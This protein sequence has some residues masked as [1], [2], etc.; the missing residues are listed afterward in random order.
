[1]IVVIA[2]TAVIALI[3][4]LQSAEPLARDVRHAP[5]WDAA[6]PTTPMSYIGVYPDGVPDSY[7]GVTAFTAATGIK[8]RLVPY[9][10]GWLEPFQ[11]GFARVVAKHGAVP[12]V[13]IDPTRT[14]LAAIAAGRYDSY[15]ITYA[16]AVRSY[17]HPVILSFGHEMNGGWYS[18]GHR[19]TSPAAFVAAWRHIV[20][21]FRA[22]GARNITWLWTINIE[23]SPN[24]PI[25]DWWP[26]KSYVTWVGVDGYYYSATDQFDSLFG[27]TIAAVREMT[28]DPILIA[29]TGAA[30]ATG[31]PAKIADLF[32]GIRT[33]GLLGFVWFDATHIENWHLSG[34]AAT[35]AFRQGA[36]TYHRPAS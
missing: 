2:A 33:Y 24:L 31:Q 13:Q 30:P 14:S 29:E 4:A 19:H 10:S 12:L 32:D 21:L 8:P 3:F 28:R 7:A 26:G 1:V 25:Q 5:P 34:A 11:G 17:H 16:E 22:L 36:E 18:W 9:Y 15:L 35:A 6:L 20:S 27:A 23:S